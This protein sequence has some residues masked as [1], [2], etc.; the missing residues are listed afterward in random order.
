[1]CDRQSAVNNSKRSVLGSISGQHLKFSFFNELI[2]PA[3]FIHK[4]KL[5]DEVI[6]KQY[7]RYVDNTFTCTN[8]LS[9]CKITQ[10]KYSCFVL[11]GRTVLYFCQSLV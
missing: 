10:N 11:S 1:M 3:N 7:D 6:S 2:T 5:E 4:S 8:C 9:L